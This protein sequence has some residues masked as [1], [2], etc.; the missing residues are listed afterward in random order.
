MGN[1]RVVLYEKLRKGKPGK[2]GKDGEKN[3]QFILTALMTVGEKALK[4]I[5]QA[6][7]AKRSRLEDINVVTLSDLPHYETFAEY[8][9]N[10][11]KVEAD[12]VAVEAKDNWLKM[13]KKVR[14]AMLPNLTADQRKLFG[15][16]D[17]P[18]KDMGM[19]SKL[20]ETNMQV[21]QQ[22]AA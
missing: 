16:D 15:V 11:T 8:E 14:D 1:E 18:D 22:A 20:V 4:E 21:P 17:K 6:E 12:K 13:S 10:V 19:G 9:A 5:Q 2:P 3:Y 7:N